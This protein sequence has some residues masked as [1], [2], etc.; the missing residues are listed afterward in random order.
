V[1][2]QPTVDHKAAL[3]ALPSL[4]AKSAEMLVEAGIADVKTLRRL[5]PVDAYRRLRF[6]FGKRVSTNF[7]YAIEC[8]L[9]GID[10]RLLE[11]ERKA[12]LKAQTK[13]IAAELEATVRR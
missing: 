2:R 13:R 11:T 7:A 10:W 5:G 3:A 4:G 9:R 12:E 6:H 1:R 8:A